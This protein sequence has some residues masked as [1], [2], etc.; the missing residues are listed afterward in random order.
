M[1]LNESQK[2]AN[3][4]YEAKRREAMERLPGGYI[5]AEQNNLLIE[6]SKLRG[7]KKDAIIDAVALAV[8]LYRDGAE[9]HKM[10]VD[11]KQ[12]LG[13]IPKSGD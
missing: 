12:K 7:S 10:I 3:D 9:A 1:V 8:S 5:T 2:K 13:L 11:A 4:K 6:L